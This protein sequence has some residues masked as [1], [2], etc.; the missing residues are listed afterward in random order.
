[1]VRALFKSKSHFINHVEDSGVFFE[2]GAEIFADK[3]AAFLPDAVARLEKGHFQPFK[4]SFKVYVFSTQESH[5]EYL[6]I[7]AALPI[8]G[9]AFTRKVYIAPSAFSFQGLDT[10]EESLMHEMSHLFLRQYLGFIKVR[11]IPFWYSEGLANI[12]VGSGGEGISEDMAIQAI[13]QGRQIPIEER[14]GFLKS[15]SKVIGKAGLSGP[16]YHRQNKMFVGYLRDSDPNAFRSLL[17]EVLEG[18]SFSK[19]FQNNYQA[20]PQEIWER[21]QREL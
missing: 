15:L 17:L 21:F 5:N 1:M 16:M 20:T 6:A 8:R 3:I 11:K 9:A 18:A 10:H 7:P 2:P 12:V 19:S 13:R 4:K 14:G